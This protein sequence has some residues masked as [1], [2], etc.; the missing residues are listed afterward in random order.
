MICKFCHSE[1]ECED[2]CK[3]AKCVNPEKYEDWKNN[4]PEEYEEWLERQEDD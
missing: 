2:G 4:N 1:E 3:C